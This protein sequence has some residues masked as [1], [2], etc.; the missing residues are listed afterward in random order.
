[1]PY[2]TQESRA[3][4]DN[5]LTRLAE[6]VS[7]ATPDGDLNYVVTRILSDWL[8]KRGLSYTAIADVVKVLETAKLE[9]YRRI[10]APYE[11]G[12]AALNGDVYGELGEG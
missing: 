10:A 8:Q 3:L 7:D 12:K 9:F 6:T 4:Y 11:D 5:A 1:M 2:I